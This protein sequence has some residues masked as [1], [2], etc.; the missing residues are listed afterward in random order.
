MPVTHDSPTNT[1]DIGLLTTLY[2]KI[3]IALDP[4]MD[5]T[6]SIPR[7]LA[8]ELCR[9]YPV[10]GERGTI[11]GTPETALSHRALTWTSG[12]FKIF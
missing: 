11:S 12:G 5:A 7:Q 1:R 3:C 2:C 4:A 6:Q 9:R 10:N 8:F